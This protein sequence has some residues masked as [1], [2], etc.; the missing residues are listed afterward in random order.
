MTPERLAKRARMRKNEMEGKKLPKR[1][2]WIIGAAIRG[3]AVD[4]SSPLLVGT[5]P[6]TGSRVL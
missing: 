4:C 5:F 1:G 6:E 3:S 2:G